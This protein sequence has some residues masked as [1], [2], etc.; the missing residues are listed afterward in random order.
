MFDVSLLLNV[1]DIKVK[2]DIQGVSQSL[3]S[4]GEHFELNIHLVMLMTWLFLLTRGLKK[5]QKCKAVKYNRNLVPMWWYL[6]ILM[7]NSAITFSAEAWYCHTLASSKLFLC[8]KWLIMDILFSFYLRCW[9]RTGKPTGSVNPSTS[10][11]PSS[12]TGCSITSP[13]SCFWTK[14]TCLR[15][16]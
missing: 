11:K 6:K 16:K 2:F 3:A 8:W 15:R 14:Q 5:K 4:S 9:W 12:T 1:W 7:N 10:L 13:L